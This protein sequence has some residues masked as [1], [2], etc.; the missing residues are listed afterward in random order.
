MLSGFGFLSGR[1]EVDVVE[2]ER[3]GPEGALALDARKEGFL[4]VI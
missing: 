2:E 3:A 1:E 4:C